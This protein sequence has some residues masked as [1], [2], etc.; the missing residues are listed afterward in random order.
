MK[1]L[2]LSDIHANYP[3]LQAVLN[4]AG[5]YDKLIFL[6]DVVDYGPNPKECLN[7]I[8]NNADYYVREIGRA[9]CRERV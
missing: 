2:I 1:A 9:S 7:F 5:N 6:G 3:A 4:N 8:K